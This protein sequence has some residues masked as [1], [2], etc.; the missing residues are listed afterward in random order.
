LIAA[1][2]TLGHSADVQAAGSANFQELCIWNP[3]RNRFS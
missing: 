1:L 2:L 3:G